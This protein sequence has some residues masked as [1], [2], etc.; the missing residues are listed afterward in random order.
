M[1]RITLLIAPLVVLTSMC[2][3]AADKNPEPAKNAFKTKTK[4]VAIFK[5][6]YGFFLREGKAALVDHWCMTDYIPKAVAG[7]FWLYTLE[8]GT[9]V[10]TVRS[11][12][13]N[14]IKFDKPA[15]LAA[16]LA[17]SVGLQISLTTDDGTVEGELLKVVDDMALIKSGKQ[18]SV[19]K[20]SDIKSVKV[21]GQPML[22]QVKGGRPDA[23]VTMRMGY[24][25]QGINWIPCYTLDLTSSTEAKLVLR[26]TITNGVEDL[27]DCTVLL[28]VGVP[29]FLMKPQFDPLTVHS[30]GTAVL[31]ALPASLGSPSMSNAQIAERARVLRDEDY[32]AEVEIPTVNVPAEGVQDL[33]F[34]EKK[35]LE[36]AAGDVVM[37]S[38]MEGVLPYHSLFTWDADSGKEV[39]HYIVLKNTLSAPLTTGPM[40]VIQG[41]KVLGQDQ[42]KYVPIGAEGRLKLTQATD[43]RTER[44]EKETERDKRE[45]IDGITYLL[46]VTE[47]QLVIENRRSSVSEVEVSWSVDGKIIEASDGAQI[48]SSAK[49][50]QGLNPKSA[51]KVSVKVEPNAKKTITYKYSRYVRA[52]V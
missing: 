14:A 22:I 47:G 16:P 15:D 2:A 32:D 20:L 50:D 18:V 9:V 36:M 39:F 31:S 35:G 17:R 29:N 6:G 41:G 3:V 42:L 33:Y 37:T 4:S 46:A 10:D 34:Y 49:S 19:I 45:V 30:L 13:R 43:I 44:I 38:I 26:A 27:T 25:Q 51:L 11:T 40:M 5:D 24:L 28:V 12:G 52:R 48:S 8:Q 1:R 23:E 21:Q 7:T